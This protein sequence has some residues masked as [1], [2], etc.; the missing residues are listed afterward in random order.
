MRGGASTPEI[1]AAGWDPVRCGNR[2]RGAREEGTDRAGGYF[3]IAST[4]LADA[5][6]R[7]QI[8]DDGLCIGGADRRPDRP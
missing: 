2:L 1:S 8:V 7:G 5:V 6:V 4:S 3:T